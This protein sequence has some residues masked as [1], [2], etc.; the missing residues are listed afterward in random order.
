MNTLKGNSQSVFN[1]SVP[2]AWQA[3]V[4]S[5]WR[6]PFPAPWLI[7]GGILLGIGA[8]ISV[9]QGGGEILRL[10]GMASALIAAAGNAVVLYG[11]MLQHVMLTFPALLDIDR[12]EG[13]R[14]CCS[15]AAKILSVWPNILA[16]LV[17]GLII[18][19]VSYNL[20]IEKFV[21]VVGIA[22][23]I[24]MFGSVGLVG[25]SMAWTMLGIGRMILAMG[26]DVPVKASL[27]EERTSIIRVASR[28]MLRVSLVAI[29]VYALGVC[30]PFSY[31]PG[32][33]GT[34]V[35]AVFGV[36]VIL[37]FIIPQFNL[38]RTLVRLK[39]AKIA[40]LIPQMERTFE[41]VAQE[42]TAE[43]L[44]QLRELFQLQLVLN[45]RTSW[46]FGMKELLLLL[47]SVVIPLL[48]CILGYILNR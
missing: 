4:E 20:I 46:S 35:T 15:R 13:Q 34:L 11:R 19:S 17:L 12:Q 22:Y 37:Y 6:L 23:G 7:I 42:P 29:A 47:G 31:T 3:M 28:M 1:Q 45:G 2:I 5:V 8:A 21:S 18:V 9:Q 36:F 44:H 38:H 39:Q 32:L 40:K 43:N 41:S 14:W 24:F 27:F 26:R 48:V 10:V 25:G 16:G 33:L 30:I